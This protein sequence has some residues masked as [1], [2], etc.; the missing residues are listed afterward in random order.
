MHILQDKKNIL[1]ECIEALPPSEESCCCSLNSLELLVTL[2]F[3]F[4]DNHSPPSTEC[5][6]QEERHSQDEN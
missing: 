1:F 3:L 4:T 6:E 2:E 5:S